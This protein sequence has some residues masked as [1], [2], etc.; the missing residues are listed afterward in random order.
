MKKVKGSLRLTIKKENRN[1]AAFFIFEKKGILISKPEEMPKP[2][3]YYP[4]LLKMNEIQDFPFD[5]ALYFSTDHHFGKGG[6]WLYLC[7]GVPSDEKNWIS[8]NQAVSEG[9]FDYLI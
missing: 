8:Y 3:P 6:I 1:V 7:N 4:C 9:H 5:H 2:G